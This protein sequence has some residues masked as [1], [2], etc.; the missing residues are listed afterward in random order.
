MSDE[1]IIKSVQRTR[2]K[3][4]NLRTIFPITSADAVYYD[5][6]NKITVKDMLDGGRI[7]ENTVVYNNIFEG[8]AGP[9]RGILK[10]GLPEIK[11][12]TI[13]VDLNIGPGLISSTKDSTTLNVDTIPNTN[14]A[15]GIMNIYEISSDGSYIYLSLTRSNRYENYIYMITGPEARL[16]KDFKLKTITKPI[17]GRFSKGGNILVV[18]GTDASDSYVFEI[19]TFTANMVSN[20]ITVNTPLTYSD[21]STFTPT[22]FDTLTIGGYNYIITNNMSGKV[23]FEAF[24]IS[25]TGMTY[26]SDI[27]TPDVY[28]IE[29]DF[30]VCKNMTKIAILSNDNRHIHCMRYAPRISLDGSSYSEYRF[31]T[32]VNMNLYG[33][34]ASANATTTGV[35]KSFS[36]SDNGN[37]LYGRYDVGTSVTFRACDIATGYGEHAGY[38]IAGNREYVISTPD[39]FTRLGEAFKAIPNVS[40]YGETIRFDAICCGNM[41]I[42]GDDKL[43][44][45]RIR[46]NSS[47]TTLTDMT[48]ANGVVESVYNLPDSELD[49]RHTPRADEISSYYKDIVIH[50]TNGYAYAVLGVIDELPIVPV[51]IGIDKPSIRLSS[52]PA[53]IPITNNIG[54]CEISHDGSAIICTNRWSSD[55]SIY[56]KTDDRYVSR[57]ISY[58]NI[59]EPKNIIGC[60]ITRNGNSFTIINNTTISA[61]VWNGESY[62]NDFNI[63]MNG[64]IPILPIVGH[65]YTSPYTIYNN[66]VEAWMM[67]F[68][69]QVAED[70][71]L[72]TAMIFSY[73]PNTNKVSISNISVDTGTD[74]HTKIHN[75]SFNNNFNRMAVFLDDG[76]SHRIYY[77]DY[78]TLDNGRGGYKLIRILDIPSGATN[79][80]PGSSLI[81]SDFKANNMA[82]VLSGIDDL[83]IYAGEDGKLKVR[84]EGL[85]V[86]EDVLP[87][88]IG[89]PS[90]SIF[91]AGIV[92]SYNTRRLIIFSFDEKTIS[93]Y[94]FN[95][96]VFTL[97]EEVISM[98]YI[99]PINIF[100]DDMGS[101]AIAIDDNILI[102]NVLRIN[103]LNAMGNVKLTGRY[104]DDDGW[105]NVKI[106]SN[107]PIL[108]EATKFAVD[109]DGNEMIM[110]GNI[111]SIW[112]P[113]YAHISKIYINGENALKY[114]Y[115]VGYSADIIYDTDGITNI[116]GNT[117]F[118]TDYDVVKCIRVKA[119]TIYPEKWV[120]IPEQ[121]YYKYEIHDPHI[122]QNSTVNIDMH[123]M[124]SLTIASTMNIINTSIEHDGYV[125]I[126]ASNKPTQSFMVD[127]D[128]LI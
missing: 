97:I 30:R 47:T 33:W 128:I 123:D 127:Y 113:A 84:R 24:K 19:I 21:G 118:R 49:I 121:G 119:Y 17:R 39:G 100:T 26:S 107:N 36:I 66:G 10:I 99:R 62:D 90:Y 76:D 108:E 78:Q 61:Y 51:Y 52:S 105:T 56:I 20:H 89:L 116:T 65:S 29:N 5:L 120:L 60:A 79:Y 101:T 96:G 59:T 93:I 7:S 98:G 83:I 104:S 11:N 69:E 58:L 109:E 18:Y 4:K 44:I 50:P 12:N 72:L 9:D 126:F 8:T 1:L 57:D 14:T 41:P 70:D 22:Y 3:D 91:P 2:D 32:T 80:Y 6:K 31:R 28:T 85:I 117:E 68:G 46:T 38:N 16:M 88:S 124:T 25:N 86:S 110:I 35:W 102:G 34:G 55:V 42:Y 67:V 71:V 81:L 82:M 13:E 15:S 111:D 74:K 64:N 115:R 95:N 92:Y 45:T 63:Y 53:S 75:I 48:M 125:E 114:S 37:S 87:E 73:N 77:Y 54:L 40:A 122:T 112:S 43:S 106:I 94:E 23:A 27:Q 103:P